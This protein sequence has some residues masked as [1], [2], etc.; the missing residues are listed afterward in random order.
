[1]TFRFLMASLNLR[2][3]IIKAA[4]TAEDAVGDMIS[5]YRENLVT[6]EDDL[7]GVLVG[8]LQARLNGRI[9]G[10]HWQASILRHR[11]GA[12]A[13]EARVGADMIFHI[14]L[15]TEEKSFSKGVLVQ[16]KR[17]NA[18]KTLSAAEQRNLRDQCR[19]MRLFSDS[20]FVFNYT[21]TKIRCG[22]ALSIESSEK[23][24]LTQD[25]PVSS[26]DF[27]KKFFE[28][29]IGDPKLTSARVSDLGIPNTIILKANSDSYLAD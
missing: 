1:M 12:A 8:S 23:I 2:R 16:A 10:L 20:S 28:C 29:T 9:E 5:Q 21:K 11:S 25:L 3:A 13:E 24:K 26:Y 15:N 22:S 19:K 17:T 27:F 18:N 7:T 6:D 14:S 4:R